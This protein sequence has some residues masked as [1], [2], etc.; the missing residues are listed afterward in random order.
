MSKLPLYVIAFFMA[1][2][3]CGAAGVELPLICP[4][5]SVSESPVI[6]GKTDD[7]AWRDAYPVSNFVVLGMETAAAKQTTFRA[8]YTTNA[9]FVAI[10]CREPDMAKL[11]TASNMLSSVD[12]IEM[13]VQPP[14]GG[15]YR[16]MIIASDGGRKEYR[17]KEK[18]PDISSWEAK[19][20]RGADFYSMEVK[21]PFSTFGA[22]PG[23]EKEWRFNIT[24][25]ATT[26]NSDRYSTWSR[27][28][29]GFHD[30]KNFG[31]LVFF[32]ADKAAMN[33]E[34]FKRQY[35]ATD[36]WITSRKET[37]GEYGKDYLGYI[38]KLLVDWEKVRQ[39]A[40]KLNELSP[41]DV[42]GTKQ[43]LEKII[44]RFPPDN[45]VARS[46]FEA[47]ETSLKGIVWQ[48]FGLGYQ[49]DKTEKHTGN[50][51]IRFAA[52]GS[53]EG[54][55]TTYSLP[56]ARIKTPCELIIS[57]WSK[58]KNVTGSPDGNYAIYIDV[59]YADGTRLCPSV[60]FSVGTHDWEY[61][62][63]KIPLPKPV[64]SVDVS[65]MLRGGHAGEA[66][67][68]D[69]YAA[70]CVE[71]M[72]RYEGSSLAYV[73]PP[74]SPRVVEIQRRV[75]VCKERIAVLEGE[76]KRAEA[77]GI[78]TACQKVSLTVARLFTD[79]ILKDAEREIEDY[80]TTMS[81]FRIMG[82][83]ET[84]RR[85][86][87]LPGFETSQVELILDRAIA[88]IQR[89]IDNPKLQLKI[90]P[91]EFGRI[92]VHDGA[93]SIGNKP[94]FISGIFGVPFRGPDRDKWI[95][96]IKLLGGNLMGPFS[97]SHK[98]VLDWDKFDDSYFEKNIYPIYRAAE[99]KGMFVNPS[100]WDGAN[101]RAPA[102]LAKLAPDIDLE[103]R[104]GW[105]YD[106]IDLDHPLTERFN[107]TWFKYVAAQLRPLTNNF[108]YS[109]MGE[110]WCH[111]GFRGKHTFQ[112]YE[113]WLKTK[114]KTID[115]LNQ[116]WGTT[117]AD[118]QTAA[119]RESLK[120]E[121]GHFN[122][123]TMEPGGKD[124]L[125][126]Q[127]T[128][129]GHYDWYAFNED[130]LTGFNQSQI[131]GIKQSDPEGLWTCW[132]AAGC[133]LSVP[134]G[135]YD[136][137]Y[138]RNRE[139]I[140]RQ[141]SV[142]G[143]D[144]GICAY[145]TRDFTRWRSK[146]QMLHWNQYTM[147]WSSEMIYYDFG[148]SICPE[149]PVFDPELHT[150]TSV[151]HMSPFGL[152]A[153]FFRATLWMEHLHGL[154]AHLL[155][156]WGRQK[157]GTPYFKEFLGGLLTQPQLLEAWGQTVLELRRLTDYIVLFP[158]LERKV[159]ILYSE[160]SAIQD[161]KVYPIQVH[162]AYEALYF[163]DYPVGFVTER[164]IR[165]GKLA[166]CSLLVIPEAKHVSEDVATKIS[167]YRQKGGRLAVIGKDSL[168]YDE[169][170][171][172]RR[173]ADF[174]KDS[175]HLTGATSEDYASQLDRMLDEA[176]IE[177]PVRVFGK[178]GQHVWGVELRT[179]MK[180]NKHIVYL[181]NLNKQPVE[182]VLKAKDGV[183]KSRDL[184]TDMPVKLKGPL[185]LEAR[186][187]MLLQ[188]P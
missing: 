180:G 132:P 135:G 103:D 124:H 82:R 122:K 185:V 11:Q 141:S 40:I 158:Q 162:D 126:S 144:G 138:G 183:R 38:T 56:V 163:L 69:V 30:P 97:I 19:V 68:D 165:E 78:D 20:Y 53:G 14:A 79:F 145:E 90:P 8:V 99:A 70:P 173:T 129:G 72:P 80:P 31:K 77:K 28:T 153:D 45:L 22:R 187:P 89:I 123:D 95:D 115:A 120:T 154:G 23:V 182:V 168:K 88:Q 49:V 10:E 170:G 57:G 51:S 147:D 48:S 143:W 136:P 1:L 83:E 133:L 167:E 188:L 172:E 84:L 107:Q 74:I 178:D 46:G 63:L 142:I 116:A 86:Q 27:L 13:F 39:K 92:S 181:I 25:N 5:L 41:E 106:Y 21:L 26:P 176:G 127:L 2:K 177:R 161:P 24:R 81:D 140:I 125:K 50:Q 149:K 156:W 121:D 111:P 100:M 131:D 152:S 179:A 160:P 16:Q 164:M 139:D 71:G 73:A 59:K 101:Y 157:D 98:C 96:I 37:A 105:F 184:I 118:F 54:S 65:L 113:N 34:M 151:Y 94:V 171:R 58:A 15:P 134:P 42:E 33:R 17:N 150:I 119:S 91:P 9:L 75:A 174:L 55:S 93:F 76:I 110:E 62:S 4:A 44:G 66:W 60:P 128:K 137:M 12:G 87:N 7:A 175:P 112:R 85:I 148:K 47:S 35:E 29:D 3:T 186:K 32:C 117:Y 67:F 108:C 43:E 6:D 102:W 114:H 169:Y 130:R 155:W 104:K 159:R 64:A 146:E 109:L 166:D 18:F 52:T 61:R 36:V